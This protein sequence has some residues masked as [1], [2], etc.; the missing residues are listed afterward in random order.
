MTARTLVNGTAVNATV[1]RLDPTS[2]TDK[3]T[4]RPSDWSDAS[5]NYTGCRTFDD[6]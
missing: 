5:T 3:E 6:V 2:E 4:K 1:M